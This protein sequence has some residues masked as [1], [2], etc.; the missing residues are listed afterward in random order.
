MLNSKTRKNIDY[1]IELLEGGV[2]EKQIQ[3]SLFLALGLSLIPV[4]I[5]KAKKGT[6]INDMAALQA[7]YQAFLKTTSPRVKKKKTR[8]KTRKKNINSDLL[9]QY[10]S[11]LDQLDTKQGIK[12]H[13]KKQGVNKSKG[14]IPLSVVEKPDADEFFNAAMTGNINRLSTLL[15]QGINI[16]VSNSQKE[17][18]LHMAAARGQYSSVI[19]LMNNGANPFLKT[20][21][22]WLP[23]HHATRF[24]HAD[25]ANYLFKK[26]LS[27]HSKT[28][29]GYS[30]IDMASANH[31]RRLL[32]VFGAR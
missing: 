19:F 8:V 25:I 16:N 5:A 22:Q 6:S 10:Q 24:R 29:D 28:S 32:S 12:K 9:S 11:L 23:I 13:Q 31:D 21:K 3:L 17:T 1:F 18:A 27:P 20:V 30:S 2:M 14:T 4:Q 15:R 7:E 26:G